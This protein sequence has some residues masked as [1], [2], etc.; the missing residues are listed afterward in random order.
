MKVNIRYGPAYAL[1]LVELNQKETIQVESG[2]MVGMSPDL[3]METEAKGG[4]LKSLGRSM[5]GGES[6]FLRIISGLFR[7]HPG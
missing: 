6:F 5:F 2:G 7:G 4:F 1:A 3:E